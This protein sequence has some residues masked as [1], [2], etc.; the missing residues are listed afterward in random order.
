MIAVVSLGAARSQ[1]P[2]ALVSP[3][4]SFDGRL[5]PTFTRVLCIWAIIG[6]SGGML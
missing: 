2:A 4:Q 3:L 6:P 1:L 5:R